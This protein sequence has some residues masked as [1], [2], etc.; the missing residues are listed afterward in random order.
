MYSGLK[1]NY[2]RDTEINVS[3]FFTVLLL[4]LTCL[5]I[6]RD[7]LAMMKYSLIHKEE[8]SHPVAAFALGWFAMSSMILAEFVNI[9]NS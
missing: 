7:G 1:F 5:P 8:F 2:I 3:L 9:A 6:A 4:H